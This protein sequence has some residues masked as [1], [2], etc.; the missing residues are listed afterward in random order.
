[1]NNKKN[2]ITV[3]SVLSSISVVILHTNGCFWMFSKERYWFTANII[4][5]VFYFAVPMFF[6]ICGANLIDYQ[7]KYTTKTYFKKRFVKTFVP[8]VIWSLLGLIFKIFY[9]KSVSLSKINL[10]YVFNGIFNTSIINIYW[11][12]IPLFCVYLCIPLFAAVD[13]KKR[14]LTFTYIAIIGFIL[15]CFIP[16]VLKIFNL[17]ISFPISLNICGD[18]LIYTIIGYLLCNYEL[19]KRNKYV[20]YILSILGLLTHIV[21]TYCLSMNAGKIIDTYKGYCNVPCILYSIGIFVFVKNI[22]K[23]IHNFKLV[24]FLSKYT[25]PIYL[26]HWFILTFVKTEFG[27]NTKSMIYRLGFPFVVVIVCVFITW[28]LRK[29]PVLKKIVP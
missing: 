17:R 13:I 24:N 18:Y 10:L 22:C 11:F 7:S 5:C 3:L 4:E 2:Y 6:M 25:F 8:F 28:I 14:K 9:L 12:F 16:F 20:I 15:N 21:G 26:I 19:T 29:V 1:M 23:K 27:I